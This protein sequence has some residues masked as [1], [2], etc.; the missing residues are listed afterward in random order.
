[1]EF[2]AIRFIGEISSMISRPIDL[3]KALFYRCIPEMV[4]SRFK[5]KGSMDFDT[6]S[7]T[8]LGSNP[9][10]KSKENSSSERISLAVHKP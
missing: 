4:I 6:I 9:M 5:P 3:G 10:G 7:F 8:A 2:V 1:M